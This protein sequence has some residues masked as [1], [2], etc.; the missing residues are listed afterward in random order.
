VHDDLE[1]SGDFLCSDSLLNHIFSNIV[2]GLRSNYR[3]IPTDCPQR[4]ERQ[5]WLG[6][7]A[8]LCEGET[9]VF[10]TAAFYRKW[11]QDIADSQKENGS[12]SDVCPAYW[13]LYL[14][15]VTWPSTMMLLPS[16]LHDQYGDLEAVRKYY[17]MLRKW[18]QHMNGFVTN[19]I[20]AKDSFGDWC[21]PPKNLKQLVAND[22]RR[23]TSK[24]FLAT[25]YYFHDLHLMKQYA[26]NYGNFEDARD[27]AN[28]TT[29]I[30]KSF[31]RKFL[32][33]ASRYDSGSQTSFILP[34]AFN[35][36]PKE[37]RQKVLEKLILRVLKVDRVHLAT[38]LVGCQWL[39][40]TLSDNG[41]PDVAYNLATQ[42]TY[43]S[44]GYMVEHG[45]TT[46]WELWN[47]NVATQKMNSENHLMLVGD[48]LTWFFEYLGGIKADPAEPGFKHI[49]MRP[50]V[51]HGLTLVKALHHSPYGLIKSEWHK[52]GHDFRWR[53]SVP[54]NSTATLFVPAE[55]LDTVTE[56]GTLAIR[57]PEL[58][59]LKFENKRAVFLIRSGDYDFQSRLP[60]NIAN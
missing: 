42:T 14:N 1:R 41:Y 28:S 56:S 11:L 30:R 40:R 19:G 55:T 20:I 5:G 50:E 2:W 33:A 24:P 53:I 44:W 45:A 57:S 27:F 3:S 37:R 18:M 54:V 38:G 48:L 15:D 49:I 13:Q 21:V 25:A 52:E 17:P 29:E 6:D 35:L 26:E 43:P 10:D 36:V 34:L 12:I 51:P 31:N 16:V 60:Q 59:P 39:M 32:G 22:K 7:R 46:V 4:D 58:I 23:K 47:G 8:A 9:Y